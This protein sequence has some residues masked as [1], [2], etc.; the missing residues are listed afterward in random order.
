ME[1]EKVDS[2]VLGAS[3]ACEKIAEVPPDLVYSG[4]E[5]FHDSE[6][7]DASSGRGKRTDVPPDLIYA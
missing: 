1:N 4:T 7:P 6:A 2:E 5:E 3:F